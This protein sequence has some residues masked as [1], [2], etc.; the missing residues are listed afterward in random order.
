MGTQREIDFRK[1]PCDGDAHR[2][3]LEDATALY[4][5]V[6]AMVRKIGGIDAWCSRLDREP[7]YGSK[8]SE[9]LNRKEGRHIHLEQLA[10]LLD[11]ADAAELLLSWL[12]ERLGYEPPVRQRT[13]SVEEQGKAL[14]EVIREL[15]EEMREPLMARAAKRLGVKTERFRK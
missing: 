15:P 9:A 4:A 7:S 11:D 8:L 3:A 12:S 10:A 13:V 2:K 5:L 1:P 6:G 14:L